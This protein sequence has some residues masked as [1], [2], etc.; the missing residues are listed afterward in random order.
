MRN[1]QNLSY[2]TQSLLTRFYKY[3]KKHEVRQR[4]N[5]ILL[6]YQGFSINE[7]KEIHHVH[8]NTIYN[9]LNGWESDGLLSL[10]NLKKT[11][12]K[13]KIDGDNEV[14]VKKMIEENPKQIKKIVSALS[15]EKGIEVSTRTVKRVL[16]KTRFGVET[17]KKVAC[18]EKT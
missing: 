9:Y 18:E 12:R 4:A 7:L 15:T 13:P 10:Y 17:G 11:G 2:E 8:L 1:I 16:K 3:S 6:S 14:F 5:T